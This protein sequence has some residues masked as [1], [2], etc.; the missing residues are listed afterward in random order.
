MG[1]ILRRRCGSTYGL[2]RIIVLIAAFSCGDGAMAA[3]PSAE[4]QELLRFQGKIGEQEL[5][6]DGTYDNPT[7]TLQEWLPPGQGAR[8]WSDMVTVITTKPP[9]Q[10]D[11]GQW[12]AATVQS[13]Q[14]GCGSLQIFEKSTK[15]QVD[16]LRKQAGLPSSYPTYS[17]ALV[18]KDP[19][20]QPGADVLL[21][22]YEVIW[23][24]G[25]KGWLHNY[26][27]QR[28]WHGDRLSP[29][30]FPVSA[31]TRQAWQRWIGNIGIA[32]KADEQ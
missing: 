21:R 7:Y 29:D 22:K 17:L 18:C 3:P 14:E 1:E 11:P 16:D 13:L 31:A 28:A 15:T 20:R 5:H 23:F 19:P 24:K 32:G 6:I 10:I 30:S 26:V 9:D 25:I 4:M 8:N 2:I 12:I 27:I